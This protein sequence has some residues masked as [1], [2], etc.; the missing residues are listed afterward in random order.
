MKPNKEPIVGL[1]GYMKG[2]LDEIP[3]S[4]YRKLKSEGIGSQDKLSCP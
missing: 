2:K 3:S 1:R 4:D